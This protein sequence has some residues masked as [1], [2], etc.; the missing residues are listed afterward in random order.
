MAAAVPN[1]PELIERDFK[2]KVVAELRLIPEGLDR[3]VVETPMVFDDGDSLPIV[4][5]KEN[6][7]WVLTDEGHTF[8]Q[9][10]YLLTDEELRT[11]GRREIIDRALSSFPIEN[12]NGE[13]VLPIPGTE[14]GNALYSFVEALFKVDAVRYLTR[15]RVHST[16]VQDVKNMIA[17]F[18]TPQRITYDWREP[19]KDP[20]GIYSVD[21][22]VNGTAEPVFIMALNSEE[23]VSVA[24]ISLLKFEQWKL[25]YKSVGI[26]D[27]M[28]KYSNKVIARFADVVGKTFSNLDEA[29]N[30]LLRFVPELVNP[31]A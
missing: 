7:H 1:T 5:K 27:E 20:A 23:R 9:L 16:F 18:S 29:R 21:C 26:Y 22:R 11:I 2:S 4:L 13:L 19:E 25:N 10:S 31:S 30:K 15:E 12:R 14:Y 6:D 3:F 28:E 24:T 8:L 17:G